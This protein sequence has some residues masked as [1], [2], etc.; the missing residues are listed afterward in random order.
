M[1]EIITH[2]QAL[3][4]RLPNKLI[5]SVSRS[6]V[7]KLECLVSSRTSKA[8]LKNGLVIFIITRLHQHVFKTRTTLEGRS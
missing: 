5:V 2:V 8:K 4:E 3:A 7:F 1:V 6:P